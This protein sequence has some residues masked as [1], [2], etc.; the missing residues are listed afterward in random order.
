MGRTANSAAARPFLK[1]AGG[2]GRLLSQYAPLFPAQIA[3][4]HEPFL[5]SG[6]VFFSLRAGIGGDVHL[7]DQIEELIGTYRAV[8]DDVEAVIRALKRHIYDR[9]HYYRVRGQD[10]AP[11][12]PPRRAARFICLNR[13][14]YNGLYRVN[15]KGEFNV[16][17]G[18]HK[19]PTICDAEGLRQASAALQGAALS[20]CGFREL[21][22]K[23]RRGDFVYLDPPY[24]PLSKTANF[25]SYTAGNFGEEEQSQLAGICRNLD[26]KGAKFMLSNSDTPFIRRLY[27]GFGMVRIQAARAI[28]SRPERRGKVAEL[29]IRNYKS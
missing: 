17:F 13:T 3:N 21:D 5:G 12:S 7:S 9:A 22:K 1:W 10:P 8:R 28:N 20:C 6:A 14:G 11:L 24:H 19:N 25:T 23:A 26:G 27:R 18:R 2:K 4:Y 15:R 29:V 16:P